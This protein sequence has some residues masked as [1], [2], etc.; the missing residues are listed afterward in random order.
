MTEHVLAVDIGGT[1]VVT[2]L[3]ARGGAILQEF[4]EPTDQSGPQ[5]GIQQIIR[6]C[7]QALQTQPD[8]VQA[9]GVGIPAV[10]EPHTDFVIWAPNLHGWRDVALKPAL[11]AALGLPVSIE[12][13]GHTAVLGEWWVGAGK[14]A[15]TLVDVII[16]TGIGGGIIA[17]GKLW[18]GHNRL[19]GAAGWFAMTSQPPTDEQARGIGHWES[20]AAGPGI[21]RR[22]QAQRAAFPSSALHAYAH[23][24]TAKE[25]FEAAQS[26]DPCAVQVVEETAQ[27]IGLGVANIVSLINPERVVLGGGIG[28][29]G[30]LLLPLVRETVKRWAQP[31]SAASVQIVS[32]HLRAKAGLFGAAYAA[33]NRESI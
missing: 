5:D 14:G 28:S 10:L 9:V 7:H 23:T 20:L 31:A 11:E 8:T 18:R 27:L 32:S 13:D 19:A 6:L 2:A 15:Q 33:W 22:A 26:G 4:T 24:L 12:Y 1:K 21:A 3:V 16:G 30:T 29:Q 17:N 25:V